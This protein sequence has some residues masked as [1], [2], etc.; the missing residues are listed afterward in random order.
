VVVVGQA[1]PFHVVVSYRSAEYK[2]RLYIWNVTHGG[3][4]ARAANEFRI[5]VTGVE[6]DI[7]ALP[8]GQAL[9]LGWDPVDEVFAAFDPKRHE[10]PSTESPSIQISRKTLHAGQAAGMASQVRANGETALAFRPDFICTY[11]AEQTNLHALGEDPVALAALVATAQAAPAAPPALPEAPP[12]RQHVLRQVVEA[13]RA[14]DFRQRVLTAYGRRCAVCGI[15]LELL[16]AAHI[17]PVGEPGGTD[18]T[19][20]GIALCSLHHDAYDRGLI[21]VTPDYKIRISEPMLE[22]HRKAGLDHGEERFR[23]ALQ[24]EIRLP[25]TLHDRP[26]REYLER[27]LALRG[28]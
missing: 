24:T 5:Q 1:H 3:G 20:N 27:A 13:V 21:A 8:G 12:E 14:H 10:K 28:W 23:A 19:S 2:A 17:V 16:Q 26:N 6:G 22:A 18:E 4:A 25:A 15:A 7:R 9:V 11:I